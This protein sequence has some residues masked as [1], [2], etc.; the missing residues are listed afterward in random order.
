MGGRFVAPDLS[1][2]VVGGK[3]AVL[4]WGPR[5]G[6]RRVLSSVGPAP[7]ILGYV[8]QVPS[9]LHSCATVAD[10]NASTSD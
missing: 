4:S 2:L 8:G 10:R 6:P 3:G 9:R 5:R 7:R 1:V